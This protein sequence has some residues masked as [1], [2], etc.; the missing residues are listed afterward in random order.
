[1]IDTH[2]RS[3]ILSTL[4]N[5]LEQ[6]RTD[7]IKTAVIV[8]GEKVITVCGTREYSEALQSTLNELVKQLQNTLHVDG[9]KIREENNHP[10]YQ[11]KKVGNGREQQTNP[12]CSSAVVVK[13]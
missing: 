8:A 9:C 11:L 2:Y 7:K 5:D 4:I 1:M 6:E 10:N 13:K 3:P 12:H